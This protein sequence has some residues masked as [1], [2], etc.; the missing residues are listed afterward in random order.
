MCVCICV[1]MSDGITA[2]PTSAS[3]DERKMGEV[4]ADDVV[5]DVDAVQSDAC[6]N[7]NVCPCR[8]SHMLLCLRIDFVD[9]YRKNV[10]QPC[11]QFH[12]SRSPS[13]YGLRRGR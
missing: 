7:V 5:D 4:R 6:D 10:P 11:S 8:Y 12:R 2:I 1:C 3:T 9:V 13:S